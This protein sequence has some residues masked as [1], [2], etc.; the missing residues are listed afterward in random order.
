MRSMQKTFA[1]G[2][3]D[4]H[5]QKVELASPAFQQR[6]LLGAL[7]PENLKNHHGMMEGEVLALY[8]LLHQHALGFQT[9]AQQ[10]TANARHR[11]A[12][13]PA[14][15]QAFAQLWDETVQVCAL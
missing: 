4:W 9:A 14:V 7:G 8:G 11:E 10:A 13:M 12:L 5:L 1:S 2:M 3:G 15:W 6:L